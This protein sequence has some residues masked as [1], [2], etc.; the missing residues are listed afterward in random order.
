MPRVP[1]YG[2]S[3]RPASGGTLDL[4]ISLAAA[5]LFGMVAYEFVRIAF[6]R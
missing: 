1:E 6:L 2:H 5:A 4:N 3:S